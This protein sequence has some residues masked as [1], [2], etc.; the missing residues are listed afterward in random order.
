MKTPKRSNWVELRTAQGKLACRFD[1][2]RR[3]IE[4]VSRGH[5]T[6]FDLAEMESKHQSIAKET[7]V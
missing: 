3:L 6:L 4:F 1:P 2:R 5:K 7:E